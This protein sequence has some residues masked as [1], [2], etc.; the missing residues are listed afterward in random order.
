MTSPPVRS[1]SSLHH[2][3]SQ[4]LGLPRPLGMR[5]NNKGEGLI[6]T[7][8]IE[9]PAT[10]RELGDMADRRGMK[11]SELLQELIDSG[12]WIELTAK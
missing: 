8:T 9:M 11:A 6:M 10:V 12:A 4:P 2:C 3:P 1:D 7:A 5:N